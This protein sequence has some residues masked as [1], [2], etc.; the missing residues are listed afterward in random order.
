MINLKDKYAIFK[1][2]KLQSHGLAALGNWYERNWIQFDCSFDH[3]Y[4]F[5]LQFQNGRK[6]LY[7]DLDGS[8]DN[9]FRADDIK[10]AIESYQRLVTLSQVF[11]KEPLVE[12]LVVCKTGHQVYARKLLQEKPLSGS[13]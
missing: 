7:L 6:V 8:C 10:D 13:R 4:Y 11:N 1:G 2:S 9:E 5:Q 12:L 3:E